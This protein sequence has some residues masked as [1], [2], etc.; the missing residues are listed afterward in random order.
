QRQSLP[1]TARKQTNRCVEP[2]LK[3]HSQAGNAVAHLF[4]CTRA[5][6]PP[7]PPWLP[8]PRRQRK[9]FCNR[10]TW[11]RAAEGILEHTADHAGPA[12]LGPRGNVNPGY[13]NTSAINGNRA[14]DRTLQG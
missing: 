8:T 5:Q 13:A 12:M 2:V 14:G 9:V 11:S 1:L 4:A 3:S 7:E 6:S 10:K